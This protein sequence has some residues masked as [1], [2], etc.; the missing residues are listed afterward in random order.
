MHDVQTQSLPLMSFAHVGDDRPPI[1]A[2]WPVH[3]GTGAAA[4]AAVYFELEPGQQL[5]EHTDSAEELLVVLEGEI[6]AVV[7]GERG[8]LRAGGLALVPALVPHDVISVGDRP[9]RVVGVFGS[10]T[11]VS[12]F[13]EGFAP[14]GMRVVG[15]PPPAAEP[16]D[17]AL[18]AAV[19]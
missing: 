1:R 17:S 18:A 14:T 4:T 7:A 11:I 16:A 5:G 19:G 9:A 8:R 10:N 15:T 2:G 13:R 3:R 6:E 12:E